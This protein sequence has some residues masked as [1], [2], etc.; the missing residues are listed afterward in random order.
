MPVLVNKTEYNEENF[1]EGVTVSKRSV[2]WIVRSI[3]IVIS[4]AS[5]VIA[6]FVMGKVGLSVGELQAAIQSSAV[7]L[8]VLLA[9]FAYS[10]VKIFTFKRGIRKKFMDS[11][12]RAFEPKTLTFSK[13]GYS[14][15]GEYESRDVT[16][17]YVDRVIETK[18]SFFIINKFGMD[19]VDKNGFEEGTAEDFRKLISE[20]CPVAKK[21]FL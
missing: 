3:Y 12:T 11:R 2:F 14:C 4:L 15:N 10:T 16:Y 8:A 20:K 5:V 19:I 18:T 21:K 17:S 6:L 9:V 13:D 7:P 1:W